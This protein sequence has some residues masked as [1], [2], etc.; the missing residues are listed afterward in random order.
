MK[1]TAAGLISFKQ[2]LLLSY[3]GF[4]P[5]AFDKTQGPLLGAEAC[6]LD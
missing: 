5:K 3:F 6:V 2:L 1:P 4:A